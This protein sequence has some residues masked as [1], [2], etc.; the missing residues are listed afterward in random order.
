MKSQ[1]KSRR[2]EKNHDEIKPSKM[3]KSEES[4]KEER[5]RRRINEESKKEEK[6]R[7][8]RTRI[9]EGSCFPQIAKP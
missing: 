4:K 1:I 6:N 7:R 2:S 9:E 3:K 5:N 8:R